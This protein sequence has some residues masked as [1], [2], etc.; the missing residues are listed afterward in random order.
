MM[1]VLPFLFLF[2][3][4]QADRFLRT[5][6]R[7]GKALV[8]ALLAG[9]VLSTLSSYPRMI[10]YF[11]EWAR[12]RPERFLN[13]SNLDWGQDLKRLAG[14]MNA[15]G[16]PRIYLDTFCPDEAP[17]LYLKGRYE[18]R[19]VD[20]G[21]P[22][23]GWFAVSEFFI[24]SSRFNKDRGRARLDYRVLDGMEPVAKIGSSIRVYRFP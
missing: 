7:S 14:F 18:R 8:L 23:T 15:R 16:I 20:R 11:T 22:E 4:V 6:S 24:M 1:P 5:S 2:V 3:G 12:S 10:G 17:D 9:F 21:L 19:P 13:D